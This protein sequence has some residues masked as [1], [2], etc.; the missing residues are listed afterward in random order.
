MQQFKVSGSSD[1]GT[2][3][4]MNG[5]AKKA[6]IKKQNKRNEETGRTGIRIIACKG[7]QVRNIAGFQ[8]R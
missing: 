7:E 8:S 6:R 4:K 2:V 5:H 1:I 3:V